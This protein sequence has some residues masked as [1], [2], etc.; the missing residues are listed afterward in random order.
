MSKEKNYN[1]TIPLPETYVHGDVFPYSNHNKGLHIYTWILL[2]YITIVY[3]VTLQLP[4]RHQLHV[5]DKMK[6]YKNTYL[7]NVVLHLL[8]LDL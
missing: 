3:R 2:Y 1:T 8:F 6:K 5:L 7:V 4:V